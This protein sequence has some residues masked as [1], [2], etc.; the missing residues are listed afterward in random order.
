MA[1]LYIARAR[2]PGGFDKLVALKRILPQ[3]ADQDDFV[4]MFLDEARVAATLQHQNVAQIHEFGRDGQTYFYTM[5]YLRGHD[6]S[7]VIRKLGTGEAA[8]DLAA[9]VAIG[10]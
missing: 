10:I 3:L 8:I 2:G 9:V 4:L 6:L 5:E 7:K 1:E